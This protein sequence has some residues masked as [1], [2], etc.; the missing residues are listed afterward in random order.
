[1]NI[2]SASGGAELLIAAAIDIEFKTAAGLLSEKSFS[3][4]SRMKMC[5]GLFSGRRVTILQS[6]M[7]APS[8]SE[9]LADHLKNNRYDA[10]IIAGLAGGLDPQLR[11]GDAVL[12][13]LCYDARAI[14]FT[15]RERPDHEEVA[16][17]AGDGQLS[18]LLSGALTRSG[19][20]SI[21]A[22]GITVGRIV[23]EAKEKSEIAA[24]Y[25]AAAVDME[26]YQLLSACEQFELPAA[27][28]RVISD[29][30]RR[31]IPDFN[32]GY[33][34]DGRMSGRLMASAMMAR[35][36]AALRVLLTIRPALQSLRASLQ[37]AMSV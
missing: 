23:T 3:E 19:V 16:A 33:K 28:L 32:R 35:P 8:F 26:T 30:A 22:P 20:S 17:I 14:D 7:G 11:V 27:A 29:D 13:N 10:M 18:R 34:T 4:E 2:T 5:R 12:Y 6:G 21:L 9:R 31:D 36:S 25:G 24:R 1:M 15:R 37:A